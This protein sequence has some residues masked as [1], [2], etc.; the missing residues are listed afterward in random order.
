[1]PAERN[2]PASLVTQAIKPLT[3]PFGVASTDLF[4]SVGHGFSAGDPVRFSGLAGGA[5]ITPGQIY[6]VIAAGLTADVFAV[7]TTVG[8]GTINFTTDITA[9]AVQRVITWAA[10]KLIFTNDQIGYIAKY[11]N[12]ITPL[13]PDTAIV[14][15]DALRSFYQTGTLPS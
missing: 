5:G 11:Q 8:G 4:T 10:A 9:G 14:D 6:Y 15:N 12:S 1:M 2:L 3:T 13:I 7:S